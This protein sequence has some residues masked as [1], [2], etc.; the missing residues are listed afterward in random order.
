MVFD[1]GCVRDLSRKLF[2]FSYEIQRALH[3]CMSNGIEQMPNDVRLPIIKVQ[4]QCR[5]HLGE[6]ILGYPGCGAL[7]QDRF[8]YLLAYSLQ[9]L[10]HKYCPII[11]NKQ[12]SSHAPE[13]QGLDDNR[14]EAGNT[15]SFWLWLRHDTQVL[16]Y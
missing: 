5:Q 8:S 9:L 14:I 11:K 13:K 2:I 16:A 7:L 15:G 12:F 6:Y 1:L 4:R 3:T 10:E